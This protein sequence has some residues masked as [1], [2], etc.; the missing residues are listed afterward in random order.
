MDQQ[1]HLLSL[2]AVFLALG[3]GILLG[4]SMS[5]STLVFNQIAVIEDLEKKLFSSR[6]EN[7]SNTLQISELE[8]KLEKWSSVADKYLQPLFADTL[9]DTSLTL[10]TNT[11]Y[12]SG[13]VEF[14]EISGCNYELLLLEDEGFD[15]ATRNS[16][17]IF[18]LAG[19]ITFISRVISQEKNPDGDNLR[20]IV[21]NS[22]GAKKLDEHSQL[23]GDWKV[24]NSGDT[25]LGRVALWE[26]LQQFSTEEEYAH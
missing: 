17:E 18:L 23:P 14:L 25:F 3:I 10:I 24:I 11:D 1:N 6:L 21:M 13:L 26:L 20:W 7:D 19:D 9:Q 5:D 4:V 22:N 12:L 2:I 8:D 16:G 15:P